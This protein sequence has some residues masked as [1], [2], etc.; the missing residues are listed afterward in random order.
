MFLVSYITR[1]HSSGYENRNNKAF[2]TLEEAVTYIQNEWYDSFC[3]L[4]NYPDDWDE[5]DFGC[6]MPKREDF[7]LEAINKIRSKKFWS[8][9]LFAPYSQYAGLVPDELHLEEVNK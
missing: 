7:S 8:G 3:G 1:A 5:E 9:E 2:N 4:N 6:S